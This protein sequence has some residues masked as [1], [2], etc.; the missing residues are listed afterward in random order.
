MLRHYDAALVISDR[1]DRRPSGFQSSTSPTDG[2][3]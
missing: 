2:G 1:R 3:G